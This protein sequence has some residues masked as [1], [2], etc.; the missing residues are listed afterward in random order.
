MSKNMLWFREKNVVLVVHTAAEPSDAEWGAYIAVLREVRPPDLNIFVVTDGGAP[1][2]KQRAALKAYQEGAQPPT[3]VVSTS[4]AVRGVVTAISW[5][6]AHI[7]AF[8]PIEIDRAFD[9]VGVAAKERREWLA[10]VQRLAAGL[11][12]PVESLRLAVEAVR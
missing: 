10:R 8:Q 3:A 4:R 6:N 11:D 2:A 1:N 7:V 9:H 12:T 5:F